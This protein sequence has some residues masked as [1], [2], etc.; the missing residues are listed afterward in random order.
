MKKAERK[1]FLS[2]GTNIGDRKK[3]IE[4]ALDGLLNIMRFEGISAVYE[5]P[6]WGPVQDQPS[7]YNLC[8]S[9]YTNLKP[10]EFLDAIKDLE[11][12]IGRLDGLRWGPRLIDVDL[13]FYENVQLVSDRLIIPHKEITG[14]AFVLIPL[15][16]IAPDLIHPALNQSV[17]SLLSQLSAADID[18]VVKSF[19]LDLSN[20]VSI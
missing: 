1:I 11:K 6:P 18:P 7:F 5:T 17:S 14:R 2:I 16:E 19:T 15:N 12:R 8:I 9:G 4:Q 3:N 10:H 13:L 20:Y